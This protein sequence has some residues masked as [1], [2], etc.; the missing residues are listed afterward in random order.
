[1]C[2]TP[3]RSHRISVP[4]AAP[5]ATASEGDAT[6]TMPRRSAAAT[7][8]DN[9][10][11]HDTVLVRLLIGCSLQGADC[12]SYSWA[13]RYRNRSVVPAR[14][15]SFSKHRVLVF[16]PCWNPL[17][18]VPVLDDLSLLV[19]SEDVDPRPV[20]IARPVLV[21]VQ[22]HVVA[23]TDHAFELNPLARVLECH[24]FEILHER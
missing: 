2:G 4:F 19:E 7:R 22:H 15:R 1:M 6:M 23:L 12:I 13:S 11:R 17:K 8:R 16:R 14:R 10:A 3:Y 24:P 20:A 21:A 18:H 9:G 5:C